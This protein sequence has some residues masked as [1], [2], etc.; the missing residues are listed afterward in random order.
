MTSTL[1]AECGDSTTHNCST[2]QE[3]SI[4]PK[5]QS[6]SNDITSISIPLPILPFPLLDSPFESLLSSLLWEG[7]LPLNSSSN[8]SEETSTSSSNQDSIRPKFDILRTKGFIITEDG[9]NWILQGVRE[10]FKFAEVHAS[11]TS[12]VEGEK[13][14]VVEKEVKPK[15]VLIG[16]GLQGDLRETLN[17]LV[18]ELGV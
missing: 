13:M 10:D 12:N 11:S 9:R 2:H 15:L 4:I 7:Q 16:R 5:T 1:V 6:H 14:D 8:S 18:N 17:D 3:H